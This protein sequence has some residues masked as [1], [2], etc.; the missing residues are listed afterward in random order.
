VVESLEIAATSAT[1]EMGVNAVL[2]SIAQYVVMFS[3][4]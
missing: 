3:A 4:I 2:T 1:A